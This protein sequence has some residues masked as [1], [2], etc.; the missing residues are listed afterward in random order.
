MRDI[1]CAAEKAASALAPR[2]HTFLSKT[3]ENAD[4]V[5][6]ELYSNDWNAPS[7]YAAKSHAF[8]GMRVWYSTV[9][10][11]T[12][13]ASVSSDLH[14]LQSNTSFQTAFFKF[15][16]CLANGRPGTIAALETN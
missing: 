11:L 8:R 3:R 14:C 16:H 4:P 7:V 1:G 5:D 10:A 15:I 13:T 2:S 6:S 12:E 9:P